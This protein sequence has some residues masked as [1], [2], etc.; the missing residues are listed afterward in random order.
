MMPDNLFRLQLAAAIGDRRQVVL[1]IAIS[2]LLALPFLVVAMP[3]RAQAAGIVMVILFTGFFGAAVSHTH[4][5]RDLRL[6]RL[7]LLPMPRWGLWT[8]L[9]LSSAL[10]RLAPALVVLT[11]FVIVHHRDV[12]TIAL[13]DLTGLLCGTLLLLSLLGMAT[14]R[15]ARST[16]EVHLLAAPAAAILALV[17]GVIGVPD[18]LTWLTTIMHWNPIARLLA[19]LEQLTA[20]P[21]DVP[22]AELIFSST[23]LG[24]VVAMTTLR[25]RTNPQ[26]TL[27][28]AWDDSGHRA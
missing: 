2:T 11:G 25:G 6:A 8:D 1:R 9:V 21:V 28:D 13:I 3:A 16:G 7:L 18:R 17:S 23:V 20:G 12:T 22:A 4:F 19:A 5:R 27:G 26:S 14:G 15:L 10:T 24:I